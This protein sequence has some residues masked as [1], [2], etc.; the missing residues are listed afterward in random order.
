MKKRYFRRK[1]PPEGCLKV[2]SNTVLTL[3]DLKLKW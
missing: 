3:V 2:L 1:I